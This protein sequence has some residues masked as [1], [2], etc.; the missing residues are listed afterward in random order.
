[1]D[2][3]TPP[4]SPGTQA[5]IEQLV[6]WLRTTDQ[7]CVVLILRAARYLGMPLVDG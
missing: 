5:D 6:A 4:A 2:P 3:N 1:M 7:D